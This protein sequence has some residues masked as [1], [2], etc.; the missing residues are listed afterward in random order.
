VV[1]KPSGNLIIE[2]C[3]IVDLNAEKFHEG[4]VVVE[5]GRILDISPL[6]KA[7]PS[8]EG[9]RLDAQGGYLVPGFWDAH[10][11]TESTMLTPVEL[12]RIVLPNGT[13]SIVTDPH[14]IANVLGPKGVLLLYKASAD[15]PVNFFFTVPSCV[16]AAPGLD[17]GGG[18]I[19]VDQV[20]PLIEL[21]RSVGLGE[22]MNFP[23]V[24]NRDPSIMKMIEL[25]RSR[26][27]IVDGH[28]P[29]IV[30]EQLHQY[31]SAGVMSDHESADGDEAMEKLSVGMHLIIREGSA[32]HNLGSIVTALINQKAELDRCLFGTDDITPNDLLSSGHINYLVRRS[33]ELGMD[34]VKAVKCATLNAARYFKQDDEFGSVEKHKQA[35]LVILRNLEGFQVDAVIAKGKVVVRKGRLTTDLRKCGVPR[36]A[37]KTMNVGARPTEKRFMIKAPIENGNATARV[38][39]ALDGQ[40]VTHAETATVQVIDHFIVPKP[41]ED[42]LTLA[43]VERHKKTGNVGL[44]LVK[45]I[46]MKRGAM[47]SSVSHDSHN[48]I[49]VGADPES[50][51]YAVNKLSD[52]GGGLIVVERGKILEALRLPLAG[53]IAMEDG[54]TVA[55]QLGKLHR[56]AK[57]LGVELKEPFMTLSFLALPVI[58]ELKLTDKGLVEVRE[59]KFVD[60]FLN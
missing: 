32:A 29:R 9:K 48:I 50:L 8:E 35:D 2:D 33:V 47:A 34:P 44:G 58:P 14:E 37:L 5:R 40:I 55:S 7:R 52:L 10:L 39:G 1:P 6:P 15:L 38:I 45:G 11:H 54:A 16:P 19:T 57:T 60:L 3:N 59:F 22:V 36:F 13:T 46:G 28:A 41:D 51:A 18:E 42:L 4:H 27:K 53:L 21:P 24:I 12:T 31:A 56:S 26:G 17:T 30:G 25:A 23:A 49:A 43:V 20:E